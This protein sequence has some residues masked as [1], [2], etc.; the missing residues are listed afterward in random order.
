MAEER[1]NI[2]LIEDDEDDFVITRD[3]LNEI[4]PDKYH[5]DW[6]DSVEK[7]RRQLQAGRHDVYLIDYRIG[8]ST[9]LE[10]L[11]EAHDHGVDAPMILLTGAKEHEIDIAA[12]KAGAADYLIKGQINAPLL[13]RSI[14]YSMEQARHLRELRDRDAQLMQA[15]KMEAV[16]RLAGGVAH[17]FNNLL[18]AITGYTELLLSRLGEDNE[19]SND[20][21]E[22]KRAAERAASLT[23]QLLSFSRKQVILPKVLDLNTLVS[24]VERMLQRLIGEQIRLLTDLETQPLPILAD[25]GQIE[26][27]VMNLAVNSRD[28][29]PR[30][31]TLTIGTERLE[32][33]SDRIPG[34]CRLS[35]NAVALLSVC[36]TGLGIDSSTM[37]HI[38][39]PFF[40]TKGP[41]KGTGLG[42]STV[43]A[44]VKQ[45][46]GD[47]KVNSEVGQGTRF[48]LYL[49]LAHQ[50]AA[51]LR[52]TMPQPPKPRI[53][54]TLL[55]VEDQNIVRKLMR[56]L[57]QAEGYTILEAPHG[58]EALRIAR[59][60][61]GP[62]DLLVTD[63]VMPEM[64]GQQLARELGALR[65]DLRV[66]FVSGYADSDIYHEI[67]GQGP[68]HFLQKPF[69]PDI[70]SRKIRDI[71]TDG[72]P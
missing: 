8:Q 50:A 9:G 21:Q 26:Q 35:G 15:Q 27:V 11:R 10:L 12:M 23:R 48:D 67:A 59:A 31:G 30:G 19:L 32:A 3:L 51:T 22:I 25:P 63:V 29:M 39:E 70:L 7:G 1:V 41:D 38:F 20:V 54:A 44:V 46:G 14:R 52:E 69:T 60:H 43:Y 53:N 40:T 68:G 2:L 47:I 57:L 33:G 45:I 13:E 56:R 49:P 4:G 66:L 17:D 55:L 28:A 34:E 16:G 6:V 37:G 5:L 36:D 42:L 71:L 61:S 18:T 72:H 58:Q 65:S 64:S 24:D 62:I